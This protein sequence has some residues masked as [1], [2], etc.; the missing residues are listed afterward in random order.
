MAAKASYRLIVL[1][2]AEIRTAAKLLAKSIA[3]Q[4][5]EDSE[6]GLA[7]AEALHA[8]R[9]ALAGAEEDDSAIIVMTH[10]PK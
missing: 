8:C 4:D 7:L 3:M 6:A 10:S 5:R 9:I 1:F 2:D